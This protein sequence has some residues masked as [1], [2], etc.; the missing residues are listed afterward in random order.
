MEFQKRSDTVIE[1]ILTRADPAD[2]SIEDDFTTRV[3]T[4]KYKGQEIAHMTGINDTAL[5][6][7][8]LYLYVK[9]AKH[10]GV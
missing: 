2:F 6:A 1:R 4:I 5:W 10:L 9:L 7:A 3:S 8:H